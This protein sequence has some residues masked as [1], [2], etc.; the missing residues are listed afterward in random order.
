MHYAGDLTCTFP[1]DRT[2][3]SRQKDVYQI[4]LNAHLAAVAAW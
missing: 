4:V 1:V 2:F 3:T